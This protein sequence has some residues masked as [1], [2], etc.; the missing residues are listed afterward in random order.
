MRATTT[1]YVRGT[2]LPNLSGNSDIRSSFILSFNGPR[3]ITGR[4]YCNSCWTTASYESIFSSA[5]ALQLLSLS[6]AFE[7]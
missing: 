3:T 7:V 1:L 4:V 6:L 5:L 2:Q